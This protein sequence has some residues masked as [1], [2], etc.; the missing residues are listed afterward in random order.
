MSLKIAITGSTGLIGPAL[1]ASFLKDNHLVTQISRQS[2]F[3]DGP[4]TPLIV[5][6]PK[7][8]VLDSKALEGFDVI[9][10]LAG[11]NV[12]ERW[13]QDYKR[14]ILDSRIDGTRLLSRTIAILHQKPKLFISASAIGYYGNHHAQH[15]LDERSPL[16][17]GF[18]AE[19][20]RQWEEETAPV[21]DAGVR[22]VNL[23]IGVVLNK[24]GG[25]LAKMWL[26]FQLGLGGVLGNGY[27][28]MS[29]I[30]LDEIAPIV[31]FIIEHEHLS[32]PVNAVSPNPVNN[33]DFTRVL[34]EVI[35]RPVF[36]PVPEFAV[37]LLFGEMGQTLLLEGNRVMPQKL[38]DAGYEF[39]YSEIKTALERAVR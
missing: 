23:R 12:G 11:A 33:R 3:E 6:D 8:G 28:M 19:V 35:N 39:Q 32:G 30:A 16:G 2:A 20:C 25:A 17:K 34:G 36:L 21:K 14:I 1:V 7:T 13:T 29:W 4:K 10:H 27:Q 22:V 38:L 15:V 31:K 24:S 9:I 26:P 37:R 18:L 5:W